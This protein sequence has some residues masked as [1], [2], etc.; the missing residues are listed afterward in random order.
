MLLKQWAEPM[1]NKEIDNI[2][3]ENLIGIAEHLEECLSKLD[4]NN[5]KH[6][7]LAIDAMEL[8][9]KN[10]ISPAMYLPDTTING[11][12][13]ISI[14]GLALGAMFDQYIESLERPEERIKFV[15]MDCFDHEGTQQQRDDFWAAWL[16]REAVGCIGWLC[17]FLDEPLPPGKHKQIPVSVLRREIE[18]LQEILK[19]P[20]TN[21]KVD[22]G[23]LIEAEHEALAE[24]NGETTAS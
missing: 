2:K 15:F 16:L 6:R 20:M 3:A 22:I 9:V 14:E 11:V 10:Y 19:L 17:N 18:Q 13:G 7:Q 12:M 24:W 4:Y 23:I 21:I 5:P 8:Y 1:E